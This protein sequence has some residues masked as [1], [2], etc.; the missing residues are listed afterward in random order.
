MVPYKTEIVNSQWYV[1]ASKV[2]YPDDEYILCY[3]PK[4]EATPF[5][6]WYR[7]TDNKK[8]TS[9]GRYHMDFLSAVEDFK[10]RAGIK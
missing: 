3:N 9:M 5:V 1:L 7:R 8:S 4:N 2:T 6:T 10:N